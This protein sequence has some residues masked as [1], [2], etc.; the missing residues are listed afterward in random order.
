MSDSVYSLGSM[1]PTHVCTPA[2]R[3]SDTDA[4]GGVR[5]APGDTVC[6]GRSEESSE[7]AN[8]GRCLSL[9]SELGS[10]LY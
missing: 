1:E 5:R 4:L 3:L 2:W 7:A 10:G 6:T 8:L 9:G